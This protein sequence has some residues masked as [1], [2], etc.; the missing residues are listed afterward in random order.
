MMKFA[1]E[2]VICF[3]AGMLGWVTCEII[4]GVVN[5]YRGKLK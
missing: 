1:Y 3:G 5:A 4:I 2:I